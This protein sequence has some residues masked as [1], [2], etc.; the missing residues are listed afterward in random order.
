ML[1]RFEKWHGC[2]NDFIVVHLDERQSIVVDALKR[3]AKQLCAKDGSSIGADGLMIVKNALA[4]QQP[5]PYDVLM[6]NPDGSVMSN[7]GNGLRCVAASLTRL[8][9]EG[10]RG[11]GTIEGISIVTQ[12]R[13]VY[14]QSLVPLRTENVL[15]RKMFFNVEMGPVEVNVAKT[16][17]IAARAKQL[18]GRFGA[19]INILHVAYAKLGNEHVVLFVDDLTEGAL[20]ILGPEL[21]KSEHW[22]GINVHLAVAESSELKLKGLPINTE[23]GY[24]VITWERGAGKTQAC[25]SGACAVAA[26]AMTEGLIDRKMWLPITMPGGTLWVM[27]ADE[28][29]EIQLSGPAEFVFEGEVEI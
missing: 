18:C 11:V 4:R 29:S 1:Q 13:D 17:G 20:D 23:D 2:K 15:P 27:H 5:G 6:I 8:E 28:D 21:Q 9:H 16:Q 26:L 12:G 25:G 3:A 14:V 7:C 24:R 19:K 22:N 10:M